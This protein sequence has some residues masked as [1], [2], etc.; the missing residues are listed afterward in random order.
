MPDICPVD[1]LGATARLRKLFV[2][3]KEHRTPYGMFC[4]WTFPL[5]D[6]TMTFRPHCF[7]RSAQLVFYAKLQTVTKAVRMTW[8]TSKKKE[9]KLIF[10]SSHW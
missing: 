2:A 7:E 10:N 9:Q 5:T 6:A 3:F 1:A 8:N 4:S